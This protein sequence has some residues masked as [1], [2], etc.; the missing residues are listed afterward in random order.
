V[1]PQLESAGPSCTRIVSSPVGAPDAPS[2]SGRGV[3]WERRSGRSETAPSGQ[4]QLTVE[5]ASSSPRASAKPTMS[6]C[7]A[8]NAS[9]TS[10]TCPRVWRVAGKRSRPCNGT[11]PTRRRARARPEVDAFL[12]S[13]CHPEPPPTGTNRFRPARRAASRSRLL[14][15]SRAKNAPSLVEAV[16]QRGRHLTVIRR[17]CAPGR[18]PIDRATASDH[19]ARRRGRDVD[20]RIWSAAMAD[21][22]RRSCRS[23]RNVRPPLTMGRAGAAPPR[24]PGRQSRSRHRRRGTGATA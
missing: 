17:T 20:D 23:A 14:V 8:V 16:E 18:L 12:R 1:R 4:G 13:G 11:C 9:M 7:P 6:W 24:G 10:R 19:L 15:R 5:P 22:T 2:R 3:R 21:P